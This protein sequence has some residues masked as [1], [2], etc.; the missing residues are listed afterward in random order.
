MV[1][2]CDIPWVGAF[3]LDEPVA[4]LCLGPGGLKTEISRQFSLD[5]FEIT[6]KLLVL[7]LLENSRFRLESSIIHVKEGMSNNHNK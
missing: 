4:M 7:E 5:F 3:A 2:T 1:E 6:C